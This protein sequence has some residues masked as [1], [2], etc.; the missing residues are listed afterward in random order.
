MIGGGLKATIV[1][2]DQALA[3]ASADLLEAGHSLDRA[4][5]AIQQQNAAIDDMHEKGAASARQAADALRQARAANAQTDEA[6][7]RIR[8]RVATA[9]ETGREIMEAGL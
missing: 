9:C 6:I 3:K 1:G 4:R 5:L 2:K 8:A 7:G